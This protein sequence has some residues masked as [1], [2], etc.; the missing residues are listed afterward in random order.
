[1]GALR[2]QKSVLKT[3]V[4]LAPQTIS[5]DTT[6][7]GE[8]IDLQGYGACLFAFHTGTVT[9]GTYTPVIEESSTGLFSGEETAVADADLY[10]SESDAAM[11]ATDDK[12]SKTV[13]YIGNERYARFTVTSASTSSGGLV[14]CLAILGHPDVMPTPSNS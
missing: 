1:M 10:V 11:A 3:A 14:S 7:D 13:A 4:A 9:D 2:E 12:A 6:T 8:A 5:T